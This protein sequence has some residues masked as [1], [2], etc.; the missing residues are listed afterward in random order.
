[1]PRP[2][3]A[4]PAYSHHKPTNQ[5]YVRLPDGNGGRRAVYLGKYNSPESRAEYA[6]LVA[7]LVTAAAV[8]G[9]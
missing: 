4:V 8:T 6:R 9:R 2:Q 7:A 1:M 3:N 5:A